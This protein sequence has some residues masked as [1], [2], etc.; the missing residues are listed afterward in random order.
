MAEPKLGSTFRKANATPYSTFKAAFNQ[1]A[2]HYV[3]WY[4]DKKDRK[5]NI[6]CLGYLRATNL[7][8]YGGTNSAE[9]GS[10]NAC[11]LATLGPDGESGEITNKEGSVPW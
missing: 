9:S 3:V 5:L 11:R 8:G 4:K 1:L 6:C 2:L 7:D 10:I